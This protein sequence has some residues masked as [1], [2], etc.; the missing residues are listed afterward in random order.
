MKT[1]QHENRAKRAFIKKVVKQCLNGAQTALK[2][3]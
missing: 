2:E 3:C 1:E